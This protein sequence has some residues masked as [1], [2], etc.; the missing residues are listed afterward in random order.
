MVCTGRSDCAIVGILAVLFKSEHDVVSTD[1]DH[2][3]IS[4]PLIDANSEVAAVHSNV[5]YVATCLR[6]R[7]DVIASAY[8]QDKR[9][10][11]T[12]AAQSSASRG[13]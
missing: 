12:A 1:V 8:R 4:A 3:F 5:A 6:G 11:V 9:I 10:A 13:K 7:E 2:C